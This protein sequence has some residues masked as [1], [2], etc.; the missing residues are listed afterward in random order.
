MSPDVFVA[1]VALVLFL[2]LR[3]SFKI[4]PEERWQIMA[5]V[6][7]K[8]MAT[9][10][11]LGVN[12][13]YYG[14]LSANA[15]VIGVACLIF[16]AGSIGVPGV[17]ICAVVAGLLAVCMPAARIIA[18]RV[19]KKANTFTVGGASFV[20]IL[21]APLVIGLANGTIG[22]ALSF[23]IPLV[24][25]LAAMAV[26]YG[27]GEGLGRLAC[28]SFGCCYGKPLAACPPIL[29]KVFDNRSF[30]FVGPTKKIAY[31]GGLERQ[32]V[33]PIQA[34]TAGVNVA[35]GLIGLRLFLHSS[36]VAAFLST[37]LI[38]QIWRVV[39]ETLRADHRGE[40][41]M[42]AYQVMGLLAPVIALLWIIVSP[43]EDVPSPSLTAGFRLLWHPAVILNLIALWLVSF[44]YTGCSKVT[45]S[46]VSLYVHKDKI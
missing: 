24:P 18:G 4:L 33:I 7:V 45:G 37:V 28:I 43:A 36:F 44:L 2:F 46:M 8:K 5:S 11:W 41:K 32:K 23:Y 39:S 27:F 42:T 14:L 6:P 10:H 19:E 17:G 25:F 13:T 22:K 35:A 15:Y 1:V 40:G 16:L 21:A 12:L 3:W 20:G 38:T 30:V 31:E 9:G 34:I 29:Q 26:A